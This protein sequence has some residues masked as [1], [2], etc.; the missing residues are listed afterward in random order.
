MSRNV[1]FVGNGLNRCY[2]NDLAWNYLLKKIAMKKDIMIS[3]S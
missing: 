2:Y 1:L 3:V